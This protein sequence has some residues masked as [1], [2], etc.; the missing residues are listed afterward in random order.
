M[1]IKLLSKRYATAVFDLAIEFKILEKVNEAER[2][3]IS[4]GLKIKNTRFDTAKKNFEIIN[5]YYKSNN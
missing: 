5:K 1:R 4:L 2:W 3:M